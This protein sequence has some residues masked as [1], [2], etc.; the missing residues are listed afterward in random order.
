MGTTENGWAGLDSIL[1]PPWRHLVSIDKDDSGS[2]GTDDDDTDARDDA[3]DD[4]GGDDD[5]TDEDENGKKFTQAD[6]DTLVSKARRDERKRAR[7]RADNGKKGG[8]PFDQ[9]DDEDDDVRSLRRELSELR[10][11]QE[12]GKLMDAAQEAAVDAG[13]DPKRVRRFLRL[14]ELDGVKSTDID[15]IIDAITDALDENPEFRK[16]EEETDEEEDENPKPK[17]K[18][19]KASSRDDT[20][21]KGK[22][23]WTREDI[24]KIAGTPEYDKHKDEIFAQVR[25]GSVK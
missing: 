3:P 16:V 8:K 24:Q 23:Q 7:A 25:A 10:A 6:L 1:G 9:D 5:D 19:A 14:A 12:H 13:A 22:R 18:R 4:D 15:A 17:R 20:S 2:G 11:E 21:E